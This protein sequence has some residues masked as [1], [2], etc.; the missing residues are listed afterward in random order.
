MR[1]IDTDGL[2]LRSSAANNI[3]GT[4]ST[5]S[6]SGQFGTIY[7]L[8]EGK[9]L[10]DGSP[11]VYMCGTEGI[12]SI[13]IANAKAYKQEVEYPPLTYSGHVGKYW[14]AHVW[15]ATGYGILK[16]TPSLATFIGPDQDDGLPSDCQGF[17]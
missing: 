5:I 16:I 2:T 7:D 6:L 4:W 3:D 12:Y 8:F 17:I 9:L 1:S 14:N 11:V 15:V 10:S 13:D